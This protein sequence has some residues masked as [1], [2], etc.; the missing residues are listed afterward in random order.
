MS[1]ELKNH[2]DYSNFEQGS[3]NVEE[4][5]IYYYSLF[6]IKKNPALHN[7]CLKKKIKYFQLR[8]V[9]NQLTS[10]WKFCQQN[11]AKYSKHRF[12]YKQSFLPCSIVTEKLFLYISVNL[13]LNGRK[14]F[15]KTNSQRLLLQLGLI[16]LMK[17]VFE[18]P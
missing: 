16:C 7:F 5:P 12:T 8:L 18:H 6:F 4:K 10:T 14:K 11:F 15:Q 3:W 17:V 9:W 2:H 1:E 13:P